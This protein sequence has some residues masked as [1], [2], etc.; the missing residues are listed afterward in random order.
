M[1][2]ACNI[3][4]NQFIYIYPFFMEFGNKMLMADVLPTQPKFVYFFTY[5]L[6]LQEFKFKL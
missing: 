3:T 6:R 1:L 2:I 5:S 4:I